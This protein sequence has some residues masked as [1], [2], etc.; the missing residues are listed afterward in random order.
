M[1]RAG[2]QKIAEENRPQVSIIYSDSTRGSQESHNLA[3]YF[4]GQIAAMQCAKVH[5]VGIT[6][7]G[8]P[9]Q[10]LQGHNKSTLS[11]LS[12]CGSTRATEISASDI[13][14]SHFDI[15]GTTHV[16]IL[17][18]NSEDTDMCVEKMKSE[19]DPKRQFKSSCVIFSL[20]RGVKN[21]QNVKEYFAGRKDLAVVEGSIGF[22]V[23]RHPKTNAY[24]PL[25]YQ[26]ALVFERLSR[27]I[28]KTAVGP[29]NLIE[30][31]EIEV[32]YRKELTPFQY[33]VVLWDNISAVN[34]LMGNSLE[35]T[36]RDYDCRLILAQMMRECRGALLV[37]A[38]HGKWKP[39]FSLISS[40]MSP[41]YFEMLCV[42]PNALFNPIA[43]LL[44]IIP[45]KGL[46]GTLL[47]DNLEGRQSM[48]KNMLGELT[49]TGDR[50]KV[51]MPVSFKVMEC[52]QEMEGSL[53]TLNTQRSKKSKQEYLTIIQSI[54]IANPS[55]KST[56]KKEEEGKEEE[57]R[58]V[59][60]LK[61]G[62]ASQR[63]LQGW[64]KRGFLWFLLV[65]VLYIS[66]VYEHEHEE[67]LEFLPGHHD[68]ELM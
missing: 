43:S 4:A 24:V 49:K 62:D 15:L 13:T 54:K 14:Y 36:M 55:Q 45:S 42:M 40:Y 19:L 1:V 27:E 12:H 31:M 46:L 17:T 21:S 47:A 50:H 10:S 20:Q 56:K 9:S 35:D 16:I 39:D 65:V 6:S 60:Q 22:G 29:C 64:L 61:I 5:L 66:F 68:Q 37:A 28:E 58:V 53:A 30:H 44:G 52:I 57:E 48:A 38:K 59:T 8:I 26:P 11:Y 7:D 32:H 67:E 51:E 18:V 3:H 63:E 41:W 2:L 33:G 23:V 25:S 34:L